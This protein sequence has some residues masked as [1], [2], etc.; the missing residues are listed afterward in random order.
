[1]TVFWNSVGVILVDFM[2]K[3]AAI[4]SDVY[5]DT[6]KKL[7]VEIQRVRLALEMTKVLLQHD[8]ARPHTTLKTVRSLAP[9]A[10]QQFHIPHIRQ[11]LHHLTSICWVASKKV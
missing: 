7:K 1:M 2:F 10:G 5:I 6:L 4:N 11:T 8:N 9:L 3:G